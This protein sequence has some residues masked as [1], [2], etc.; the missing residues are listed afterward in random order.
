MSRKALPI[1]KAP[2]APVSAGW[3]GQHPIDGRWGE[4]A[5]TALDTLKQ[6]ERSRDAGKA[7]KEPVALDKPSSP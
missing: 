5:A 6:I 7:G 4:G 2:P 3:R 1:S